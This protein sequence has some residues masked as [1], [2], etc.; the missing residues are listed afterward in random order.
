MFRDGPNQYWNTIDTLSIQSIELVRGQGS[1]LYGSDAIG[2]TLNVLTKRPVYSDSEGAIHGGRIYGRYATA[3]DSYTGRVEGYIS[4][5]DHYGL[6]LG[7]S[8]KDYE[9]LTVAGLGR[10]LNTGYDE[11]D[12]DAKFEYF[13]KP[14]TRLTVL[15][16]QVH[17]NDAWRTH[18]TIFGTSFPGSTIGDEQRR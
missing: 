9:D 1:A 13:L 17:Q 11:W 7:F 14:D 6:L 5:K 3:E 15:H 12:A 16:Q 4:E 8:R 2:C 18:K 10:Q